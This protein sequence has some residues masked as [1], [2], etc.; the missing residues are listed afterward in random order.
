MNESQRFE[1]DKELKNSRRYKC[2]DP[3]YPIQSVYVK[4]SYADDND[5]IFITISENGT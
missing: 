2:T 5:T 3:D 1:V 4:R